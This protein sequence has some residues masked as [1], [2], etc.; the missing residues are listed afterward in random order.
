[1]GYPSALS[2]KTWGFQDV[3]FKGK[4]LALPSF[5]QLCLG[6]VLFKDSFPAEFHAQTAVEAAMTLHPSNQR[7]TRPNRSR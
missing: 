7:Q 6:D 2:A 4:T 5:R 3:L 1:M